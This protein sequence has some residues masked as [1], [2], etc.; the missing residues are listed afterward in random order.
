MLTTDDLS[1]ADP[2]GDDDSD[3]RTRLWATALLRAGS[4]L[5]DSLAARLAL[6]PRAA[7]LDRVI[8]FHAEAGAPEGALY[9]DGQLVGHVLGVTRL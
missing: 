5:L 4:R 8:E 7:T 9:V 3:H 1:A 6:A 2:Y